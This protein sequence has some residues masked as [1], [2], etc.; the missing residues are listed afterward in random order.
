LLILLVAGGVFWYFR[1]YLGLEGFDYESIRAKFMKLIRGGKSS[2]RSLASSSSSGKGAS[3]SEIKSYIASTK[4]MGYS[5]SQI[6]SALKR[7]GW[8]GA[9]IDRY[10]GTA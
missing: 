9:I 10:L 2:A 6:R 3:E 5:S 8:S 7:K 1:Y 4:S